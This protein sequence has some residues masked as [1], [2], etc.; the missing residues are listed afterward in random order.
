M[1]EFSASGDFQMCGASNASANVGDRERDPMFRIVGRGVGRS[2]LGM[3]A[4]AFVIGF[5][6][7]QAVAANV[8]TFDQTA[9]KCG[10]AVMCSVDGASGY[11]G[12][13]AF[14]LSTI[15]EWFQ[16]DKTATSSL[17]AGQPIE[18]RGGSGSFLVVND[19]GSTVT[20]FS[21]TIIDD[22]TSSTP[23]VAH[24][25]GKSGPWCD[26][27]Q[28]SKGSAAPITATEALSGPDFFKCTTGAAAG[29]S[30]CEDGAA[31]ALAK[32]EP[33]SVTYVWSGL[34]ISAGSTFDISFSG[35]NN[36]ARVVSASVPEPSTWAMLLLGFA[37][38]GLGGY[39]RFGKARRARA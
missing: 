28:A 16:I 20:T 14:D 10:G 13:Q 4:I 34:F 6:V 29:G 23:S 12:A 36:D 33:N 26:S 30:P 5:D 24:C 21:I 8:I 15:A 39:R 37:G 2:V 35:W 9:K 22:F 31:L 3:L 18:P 11:S 25:S 7:P 19:T 38:I 32:F 17:I 1:S 27:F